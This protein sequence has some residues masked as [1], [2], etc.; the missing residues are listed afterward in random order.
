MELELWSETSAA[1]SAV[2]VGWARGTRA[3]DTLPR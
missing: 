3:T 2:A 1:I